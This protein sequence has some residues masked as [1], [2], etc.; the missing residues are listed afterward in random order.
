MDAVD[1]SLKAGDLVRIRS[2]QEIEATLDHWKELEG[3]AFLEY[4]WQYC[5]T[6]QRLP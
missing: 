1:V 2:R 5:D 4:M 3:C 6:M